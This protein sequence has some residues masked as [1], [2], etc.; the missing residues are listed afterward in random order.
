[1]NALNNPAS[2]VLAAAGAVVVRGGKLQVGGDGWGS[3]ASAGTQPASLPA[4]RPSHSVAACACACARCRSMD[5]FLRLRD[6][7]S[8]GR[9][10]AIACLDMAVDLGEKTNS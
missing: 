10:G 5:A 7:I 3:E 4:C 9:L 6:S 8:S 1:M 2:A